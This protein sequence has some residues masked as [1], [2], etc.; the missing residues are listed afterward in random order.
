MTTI[1]FPESPSIGT[2]FESGTRIWEWDGQVWV[3]LAQDFGL[4]PTGPT[5]VR[6]AGGARGNRGPVGAEG[7]PL[8]IQEFNTGRA[9]AAASATTLTWGNTF[10]GFDFVEPVLKDTHSKYFQI[11]TGVSVVNITPSNGTFQKMTLGTGNTLFIAPAL[12][13]GKKFILMIAQGAGAG[14]ATWSGVKWPANTAP[15]ITVTA[16]KTDIFE[17]YCDGIFWYGSVLGQNF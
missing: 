9:L 1:S 11:A 10:T 2:V 4:G 7:P 14:T 8:P 13:A 5:G 3:S 16:A 12:T 6:G 15:T 17:F